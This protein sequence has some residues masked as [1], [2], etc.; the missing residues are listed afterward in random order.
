[1]P[2]PTPWKDEYTLLCERCGYILE[3][4]D[5]SLPC[6]EC[7]KPIT[8]SLPE[9]RVGTPWQQKP[10]F[11]SLLRT[12]WM[13]IRHPKQLL[14]IQSSTRT[15]W[16]SLITITIASLIASIGWSLPVYL[17]TKS[18]YDYDHPPLY[19]GISV[20]L[21]FALAPFILFSILTFIETR[22][23]RFFGNRRCYRI[24]PEFSKAITAHGSVG[25]LLCAFG[26]TLAQLL[27]YALVYTMTPD[28]PEPTGTDSLDNYL[29]LFSGPP[30]WVYTVNWLL[31]ALV[32]PGFLFFETFAYLG[33]RRCK[34]ANT[35]PPKSPPQK[36]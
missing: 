23:L 24:T 15:R 18:P 12:W 26:L 21:L 25:W 34:Y 20:V 29:R 2:K 28:P 6:P 17:P 3:D 8:E 31:Y 19:I 13:T 4:L 35:L 14:D 5:Q 27:G 22:G 9:R 33:L 10:G 11:K 16:F 7:G 32:L 36:P 30:Q 1:M